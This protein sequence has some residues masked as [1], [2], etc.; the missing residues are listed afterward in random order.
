MRK[1]KYPLIVLGILSIITVAYFNASVR[2]PGGRNDRADSFEL[3]S[4]N[5][6]LRVVDQGDLRNK[7][8]EALA[9]KAEKSGDIYKRSRIF[10]LKN[11]ISLDPAQSYRFMSFQVF[12]D[13]SLNL[14]GTSIESKGANKFFILQRSM[15]ERAASPYLIQMG[16]LSVRSTLRV[17][18]MKLQP[19]QIIFLSLRRLKESSLNAGMKLPK[20]RLPLRE[21]SIE[22][23]K[24]Y[25]LL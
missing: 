20:L 7:F 1:I 5:S 21:L 24:H 23:V 3:P 16:M 13:L 12:D 6:F 4:L 10:Q 15:A 2:T 17:K 11:G 8:D 19:L 22:V 14:V 9:R 18:N 25:S